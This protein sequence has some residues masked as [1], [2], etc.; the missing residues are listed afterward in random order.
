MRDRKVTSPCSM[1][2]AM[3]ANDPY[4]F[5]VRAV[6]RGLQCGDQHR[7]VRQGRAGIPE[8]AQHVERA[9]QRMGDHAA[10]D[11]RADAVERVFERRRDAEVAA[12]AANRPEQIRVLVGAGADH[13]CRRP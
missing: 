11:H 9:R 7:L 13:A 5:G 10:R 2:A 4:Q 6:R 8:E 3:A 12:A 1:R